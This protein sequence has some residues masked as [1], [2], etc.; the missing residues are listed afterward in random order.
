MRLRPTLNFGPPSADMSGMDLM[1][2]FGAMALAATLIL[3]IAL[4]ERA[5]VVAQLAR[6]RVDERQ[7]QRPAVAADGQ[8]G[9]DGHD[10]ERPRHRRKALPGRRPPMRRARTP[11]TAA[12]TGWC[13]A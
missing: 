8:G 1:M 6:V 13:S 11:S 10:G 4:V 2:Q 3:R 12:V 9:E 5:R 7:G